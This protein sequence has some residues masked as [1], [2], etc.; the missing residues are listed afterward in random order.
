MK[1][2]KLLGPMQI[3]KREGRSAQGTLA[4]S[5]SETSI[6]YC[7]VGAF[8]EHEESIDNQSAREGKIF[9]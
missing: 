4:A 7:R 9:S 6:G 5:A 8:Q 2:I 3:W 1:Q